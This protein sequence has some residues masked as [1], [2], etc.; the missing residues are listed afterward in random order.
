[1]Y[2]LVRTG[3][4]QLILELTEF[5]V[6]SI[7]YSAHP[8]PY[9]NLR[10]EIYNVLILTERFQKDPFEEIYQISETAPSVISVELPE[11]P[12]TVR[13]ETP[14]PSDIEDF[15]LDLLFEEENNMAQPQQADF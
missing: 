1:L 8:G 9:D 15:H 12:E 13:S 11:T 3:D 5:L 10:Q 6:I 2:Q 4:P 14:E 7:R